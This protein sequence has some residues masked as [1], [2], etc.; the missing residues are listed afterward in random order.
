M[1]T[2][3]A[4]LA[5]PRALV[6]GLLLAP[7][8]CSSDEAGVV[9]QAAG[10]TLTVDEAARLMLESPEL[11]ADLNVVEAVAN[12]WVDYTLMADALLQ[13]SL[14]STLELEVIVRSGLEQET[15]M[16]LRDAVIQADTAIGDDDLRRLFEQEAPGVRV[17]A[18]HILLTFPDSADDAARQA[19]RDD[20]GS[21]LARLRGGADFAE[22]ARRFSQDPG[23]AAR[24]GD[25]GFFSRGDM[26][27]PFEDAAFAL[28]IGDLSD[29]V[30]SPFGLH[31]ILV[32]D[33]Q[34][35]EFDII[36]DRFRASVI[37]RRLAEAESVYIS[38][39][40][41]EA[42]M[43]V[44]SSTTDIVRQIAG[45]P[46]LELSRRA[47]GRELVEYEG[48]EVTL[49]ELKEFLLSR[50]PDYRRQ[51]QRAPDDV[52]VD[53]LLIAITQRELL[54]QK[55]DDAGIEPDAARVDSLMTTLRGQLQNSA[56]RAQLTG[57][58]P[59]GSETPSQAVERRVEETLRK[60]MRN[61]LSVVP[62]DGLAPVLRAPSGARVF[63]EAFD[64]VIDE[65]LAV[66]GPRAAPAP[67]PAPGN[68]G[69][70]DGGASDAA[71]GAADEGAS[72]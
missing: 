68:S 48:G 49:G 55:A 54:L 46:A 11:A 32:E 29:V 19:V 62:F 42:Q 34:T 24:G 23:S 4:R 22:L 18:R 21:L 66:R 20:A 2:F 1:K 33:K 56:A 26:V 71:S 36:A 35:P 37:Q 10:N 40:Q 41:E 69:A 9:A 12:L 13:D 61:E 15:I 6:F 58:E 63:P 59:Q 67:A 8:A 30:E 64:R 52:I 57:I 72:P 39:L 70:G 65:V 25:L 31:L 53:Q 27:K 47:A 50:N 51:V 5:R 45:D 7:L 60:M 3:I 28:G 16:A 14:L 44:D 17:K 38:T 43:R